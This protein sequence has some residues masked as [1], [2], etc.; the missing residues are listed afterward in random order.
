MI[1]RAA[2]P[3]GDWKTIAQSFADDI[4]SADSLQ[5]DLTD[6]G[7]DVSAAER[8]NVRAD[9]KRRVQMLFRKQRKSQPQKKAQGTKRTPDEPG[10]VE[11]AKAAVDW[12]GESASI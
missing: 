11:I 9:G 2:P 6:L 5:E 10:S 8:N 4:A 12:G 1:A 3:E 7:L